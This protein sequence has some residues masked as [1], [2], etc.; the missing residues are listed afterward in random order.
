MTERKRPLLDAPTDLRSAALSGAPVI[1][2][3]APVEFARGRVP[4]AT[5]APLL[6]DEQRARVGLEYKKNGQAAAV[7]LGLAL[8]SGDDLARKMERW[9]SLAKSDERAVVCCFRGGLRSQS[10]AK[11]LAEAGFPR[12]AL[13]GGYKRARRFLLEALDAIPEAETFARIGGFTGAGKTE[14][15]GRVRGRARAVCLETLARHRG[16]AFGAWGDPQ[17][18]LATFENDLAAE[19]WRENER[20]LGGPV[21]VED[22]SRLV[23]RLTIPRALHDRMSSAPLFVAERPRRD[24]ARFLAFSYLADTYGFR[25]GEPGDS[26]ALEEAERATVKALLSIQ[27]RL[28]GSETQAILK[29]MQAAFSEQRKTGSFEAHVDWVE[30]ALGSYYDPAYGKH[31]AAHEELVLM[32]GSPEEVTEA[33]AESARA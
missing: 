10:V 1:D 19:L 16:S 4:G 22:E 32:R 25:D 24:R 20:P 33:M 5:N 23:G 11:A 29:A 21:W 13:A 9:T 17:P 12:P 7:A 3:R 8:V 15:L 28:G 31:L 27:K 2:V 6:D 26:S 18:S 14:I 30:R